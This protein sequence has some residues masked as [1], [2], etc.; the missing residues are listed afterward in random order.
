MSAQAFAL[1]F[2]SNDDV[3]WK[4]NR[5]GVPGLTNVIDRFAQ[6]T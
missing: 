5:T 1:V 6:Y 4:G 3:P 2:D